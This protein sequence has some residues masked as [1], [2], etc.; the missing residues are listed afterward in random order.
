[1]GRALLGAPRSRW[2][3]FLA[4]WAI[5][6]VVSLVPFLNIALW[7]LGSIFGLGA[8][9]VATW[10]ARAGP[11]GGRHRAGGATPELAAAALTVTLP[12]VEVPEAEP[13]YPATSDD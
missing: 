6:G 1:M 4:G 13:S 9:L 3:A 10:R 2:L 7:A 12:P 11:R 8:M 5:V